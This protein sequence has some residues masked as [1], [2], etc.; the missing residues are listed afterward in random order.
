MFQLTLEA[1]NRIQEERL[2]RI[3]KPDNRLQL[4]NGPPSKMDG[5]Y[6][7]YTSYTNAELSSA[8]PSQ[9]RN[10]VPINIIAARRKNLGMIC[11]RQV[12]GFRV[13]YN[14][15]EGRQRF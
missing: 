12:D 7:L 4:A 14:G 9:K 13:V 8:V 1:L 11:N 2:C 10:S 15:I 6:W 3:A 5:L